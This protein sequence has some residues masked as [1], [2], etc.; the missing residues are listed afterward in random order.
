MLI[1]NKTVNCTF[2]HGI[3]G[4]FGFSWDSAEYKRLCGAFESLKEDGGIWKIPHG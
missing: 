4:F 1:L 3:D 2:V